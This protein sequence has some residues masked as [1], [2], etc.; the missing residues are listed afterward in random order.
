MKEQERTDALKCVY[1]HKCAWCG[2]PPPFVKRI[3]RRPLTTHQ[4]SGVQPFPRYGK[5]VRT[6]TSAAM[7]QA[8]P[9]T[10]VKSLANEYLITYRTSAQS[11]QPFPRCRKWGTPAHAYVRTCRCTQHNHIRISA[12]EYLL[13][14]P[15][16]TKLMFSNFSPGNLKIVNVTFNLHNTRYILS[17]PHQIGW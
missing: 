17:A 11:V 13:T 2:F 3:A 4:V 12:Y 9:L 15:C 5:G 1:S 6:C 16:H 10:S 14:N 8:P 7:P